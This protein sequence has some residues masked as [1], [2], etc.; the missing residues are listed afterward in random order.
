MLYERWLRP[1][2]FRLDPETAHKAAARL[3]HWTAAVPGGTSLLAAVLGPQPEGL[4]TEAFGLNFPSP[5]GL[6]AGFDKDGRLA[7]LLP[8]LGFGFLEV[9]SIT[10]KPQPGN[11]RP[12]IF[13]VPES[14][15]IINRLGFNS[16]GAEAAARRLK[17]LGRLSVPLGV[18]LGLNAGCPKEE[19]P[20]RYA[21]TFS[22]LEP[23][24]DY[25]VVNVSSPNTPG[26]R[27]LQ[28][29]LQ[30]ER[31]LSEISRLNPN[32]K[33]VLVKIDPDHPD[34]ELPDLAAL[35]LESASG[36][37]ASNTT[38]TRSDV[39][40]KYLDVRGGLSGAPL[41]DLSTKLIRRLRKLTSGRLPIIG[42]GGI[43]TGLDAYEKIRAG[44]CLVQLYTGLV[45][46][47]P[48]AIRRIQG[49]L[50]ECLAVGGYKTVADAVGTAA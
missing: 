17:A 2:L 9:G 32:R 13:R 15:A 21:E 44:A 46:R 12:R 24:G 25:F 41:R 14:Q 7:G 18:N 43:F 39:P 28:E 35:L 4:A 19:A 1:L 8:Q 30:L 5:V 49:E 23:Y 26:L 20:A 16:E 38:V 27:A 3:M 10:L 47:G 11:P 36:V 50:S 6:A 42:V 33:P 34:D 22:L 40:D 48:A 37:I 31:I 29:R 45:Y